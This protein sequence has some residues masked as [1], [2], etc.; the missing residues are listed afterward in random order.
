MAR[1]RYRNLIL[2]TLML[3]IHG[4]GLW[5]D[6]T[7]TRHARSTS[8][9]NYL[10]PNGRIPDDVPRPVLNLPLRVGLA[11]IPSSSGHSLLGEAESTALLDEIRAAFVNK[12]YIDDVV[13]VPAMYLRGDRAHDSLQQVG[14]MFHLDVMALVSYD[15]IRQSRDN[16]LSLTYLTIV[17]AFVV[18]GTNHEASTLVDLAVVDLGSRDILFRAAG[19]S[20]RKGVRAGAYSQQG[21]RFDGNKTFAQAMRR[22]QDNLVIELDR[23]EQRLREPAANERIVVK[24]R[25]GYSGRLSWVWMGVLLWPLWRLRRRVGGGGA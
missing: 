19:V 21:A 2:L 14:R 24:H 5:M 12:P 17:G 20:Q 9:V 25:P 8:L 16:V 22:M 6:G 4:C 18:P 7:R 1:N 23:F 15:Q 13:V 10:Y 3:F 11:V